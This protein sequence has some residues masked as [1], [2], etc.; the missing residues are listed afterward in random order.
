M[1]LKPLTKM[2]LGKPGLAT[3]SRTNPP[4]PMSLF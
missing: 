2:H 3:K 4:R 1:L